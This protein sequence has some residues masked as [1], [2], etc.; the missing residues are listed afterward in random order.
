LRFRRKEYRGQLVQKAKERKT[1]I[2]KV[3]ADNKKRLMWPLGKILQLIEGKDGK[4]RV[5][6]VKTE[7]EILVRTLQRLYPLKMPTGMDPKVPNDVASMAKKKVNLKSVCEPEVFG[8]QNLV[9]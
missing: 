3:G 9:E 2:P 1:P 6:K 8:N 4:G 5:A 7:N